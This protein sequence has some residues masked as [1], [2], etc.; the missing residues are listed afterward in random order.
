M[1][2][3][4][5]VPRYWKAVVAGAACAME[6]MKASA[7]AMATRRR[8]SCRDM[9][10]CSRRSVIGR[11]AAHV[12]HRRLFVAIAEDRVADGGAGRGAR[13]ADQSRVLE[14]ISGGGRFSRA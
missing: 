4:Y 13:L 1:P 10:V 6:K 2:L 7:A 8:R 9:A 3:R 5:S 11:A 12:R 14:R